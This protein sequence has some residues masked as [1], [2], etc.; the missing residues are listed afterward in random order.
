MQLF[1]H[2]SLSPESETLLFDKEESTHIYKVLRKKAG[3]TLHITDGKGYLYQGQILEVSDKKCLVHLRSCELTP[4]PPYHL[5]MVVAPTKMNERYE[6]F[7]EKAMEIGL[8]ELTPI[9][10]EH[11]ERKV[12][13]T[14]R[15]EKILHTAKKQSLQS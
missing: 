11:S 2:P 13:K 8:Q 4:A 12:I 10:C 15:L 9:I 1:Y 7:V 3:D 6:W 14:E 5:H